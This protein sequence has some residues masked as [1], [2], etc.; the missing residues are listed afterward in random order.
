MSQL[1]TS[2]ILYSVYCN[3]PDF[4]FP[5][6]FAFQISGQSFNIAPFLFKYPPSNEYRV[7]KK[8]KDLST[9]LT[10]INSGGFHNIET[11]KDI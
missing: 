5:I 10:L 11:Y 3:T 7:N 6:E 1:K 4:Q 8:R 9:S 2:L